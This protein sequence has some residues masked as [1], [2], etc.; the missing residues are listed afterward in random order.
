[1]MT[2]RPLSNLEKVIQEALAKRGLPL[3]AWKRN[4]YRDWVYY[5]K[6]PQREAYSD[7]LDEGPYTDIIGP[8]T[9]T[10]EPYLDWDYVPDTDDEK[11]IIGKRADR[12]DWYVNT[13]PHDDSYANWSYNDI[14]DDAR[15]YIIRR[16]TLADIL[17]I[18]Y[19]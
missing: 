8:Y 14:G 11:A 19:K 1:M 3:E 18:L 17:R 10:G 16:P 2:P 13:E 9:D 6:G 7:S 12:P 5:N 4:R 15:T